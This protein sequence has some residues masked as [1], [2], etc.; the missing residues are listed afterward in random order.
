MTE[1]TTS[2]SFSLTTREKIYNKTLQNL[3]R[4][5]AFQE[6]VIPVKMIESNNYIY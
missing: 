3:D 1:K 2:F 5:K 6:N 4:K